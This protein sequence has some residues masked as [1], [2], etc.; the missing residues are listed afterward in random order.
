MANN[1]PPPP[2]GFT[3][4][5]A[6]PSTVP[7]PPPGFTLN[8]SVEPETSV[9]SEAE[10]AT[11]GDRI[12]AIVPSVKAGLAGFAGMP[13]DTMTKAIDLGKAAIGTGYAAITGEAPPKVL[14]PYSDGVTV[15][16]SVIGSTEWIRSYLDKNNITNT[17]IP[18]PDDKASRYIAAASSAVPA[19]VTGRPSS[20]A[21]ALTN[22]LE[23]A[24][25][26]LTTQA[27]A[28]AGGS[29]ALQQATGL[30]ASTVRPVA[31]ALLPERQLAPTPKARK[32]TGNMPEDEV[33]KT[34][35]DTLLSE[36]VPVSTQQRGGKGSEAVGSAARGANALLGES[37]FVQRQ[38]RA[39]TKAV[40]R[41]VGLDAELATTEQMQALK[42]R[43]AGEYESLHSTPTKL[44][45]QTMSDLD[46]F[47]AELPSETSDPALAGKFVKAVEDLRASAVP[48][49]EFKA[50]LDRYAEPTGNDSQTGMPWP[51][52]PAPKGTYELNGD[53]MQDMRS[54]LGRWGS[55]QDSSQQYLAER[56]KNILDDA[57]ERNAPPGDAARMREV[58]KQYHWM[59]QIEDSV[60]GRGD[61]IITPKK[62]QSVLGKAKN[63]NEKV[64]GAGDQSLVDLAEAGASVLPEKIADSGTTKRGM[65]IAKAVAAVSEPV[66]ATKVV[67]T[68]LGGRVANEY[69]ALRGSKTRITEQNAKTIANA[70]RGK[71]PNAAASV[72][73][74]AE[75]EEE[76]KRRLRAEA[77]RK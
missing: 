35:V 34:H 4:V 55:S 30:L 75:S 1:I 71:Q 28:E 18:R 63:R 49:P 60:A 45:S 22:A 69:N 65:D 73:S 23:A 10:P 5:P 3:I 37:G 7:P 8:A 59:K 41:K 57:Y 38:A 25:I 20:A 52:G 62:L 11:F 76:R 68:L 26:G 36:D 17:Q 12:G 42:N 29:P 40:L 70:G 72:I 33:R 74:T 32:I 66:L 31:N 61:G 77:L 46:A 6:R 14:E 2:P 47:V 19:L 16:A 24:G 13:V 15:P 9:S 67:G 64:F 53:L 39:F 54:R 27:V 44:D 51:K 50:K 56:L 21:A 58:R 43:A 48:D